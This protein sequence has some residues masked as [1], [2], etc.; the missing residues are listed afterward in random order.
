MNSSIAHRLGAAAVC[1]AVFAIWAC[2][3]GAKDDGRTGFVEP[4]AGPETSAGDGSCGQQGSSCCADGGCSGI[5]YCG[6]TH[7]CESHPTDVGE[8]CTQGSQCISG[9]CSYPEGTDAGSGV[10]TEPCLAASDCVPGWTCDQGGQS[11]SEG[12]GVCVCTPVTEACDGKDDNCDGKIDEEPGADVAC[13]LAAGVPKTCVQGAC[14]CVAAC[15]DAGTCSDLTRDPNNCGACGHACLPGWQACVNSECLCAGLLCPLPA[16]GDAGPLVPDGGADGGAVECVQPTSDPNNCG[17]CGVVCP[18][19]YP[20]QHGACQPIEL[21]HGDATDTIAAVVSD[22]TNAFI[23]VSGSSTRTLEECAVAGCNQMPITVASGG[24]NAN[25][26]MLALLA[27]GGSWVY[28]ASTTAVEDLA[29]AQPAATPF[30]A[31][32]GSSIYGVATNSTHVFWSDQNLGVLTCATGSTCASPTV[33]LGLASISA[34]PQTIAADET[35]VYWTD[36]NGNLFSSP[37]AGGTPS[38]L[39]T[40]ADTFGAM[41]AVAGHVYYFSSQ[42]G[43]IRVAIGGTASSGAMYFAIGGTA[44][45]TDGA[46]LYWADDSIKKCQLGPSCAAPTVLAGATSPTWLAVDATHTYWVATDA[47]GNSGV[48][49]YGK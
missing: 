31:P 39:A 4:D 38:L 27:L 15:G 34:P 17:A 43:G 2:A 26:S 21:V 42:N 8:P 22:G 36:A 23:L 37:V 3:G 18:S 20:C 7:V 33:L 40:D 44:I 12:Q 6:K 32:S 49:E 14:V 9:T 30:A 46:T 48:Y 45:A 29:T 25:D 47:T 35:Y 28:W 11:G 16:A 19:P 10:C 41:V 1:G 24:T 5:S 13:S